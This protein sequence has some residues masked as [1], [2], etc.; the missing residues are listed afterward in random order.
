MLTGTPR[1]TA[2]VAPAWGSANPVESP[3]RDERRQGRRG[4]IFMGHHQ[5][6]GS[7]GP[8]LQRHADASNDS[9][10]NADGALCLVE[11]PRCPPQ[12]LSDLGVEATKLDTTR[13]ADT[14]TDGS[15]LQELRMLVADFVQQHGR[16]QHQ[17]ADSQTPMSATSPL[18]CQSGP[19]TKPSP[20]SADWEE[21]AEGK[22]A[23]SIGTRERSASSVPILRTMPTELAHRPGLVADLLVQVRRW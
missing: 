6:R 7:R 22:I 5:T 10:A 8:G 18:H 12:D 23:M 15:H 14:K 16:K 17:A 9:D 11:S 20:H 2:V 13:L 4:G 19:L 1:K 3:S 21:E